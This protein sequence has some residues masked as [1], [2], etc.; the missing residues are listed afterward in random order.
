MRMVNRIETMQMAFVLK[1]LRRSVAVLG[2]GFEHGPG[3]RF[4]TCGGTPPQPKRE[5]ACITG[6]VTC[7]PGA[8]PGSSTRRN[9]PPDWFPA[10]LAPLIPVG[11]RQVG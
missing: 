2:C 11:V 5:A 1:R 10:V 7:G 9:L 6:R 8:P 3:A 4:G